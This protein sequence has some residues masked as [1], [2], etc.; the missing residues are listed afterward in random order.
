MLTRLMRLRHACK[1]ARNLLGTEKI[2][3]YYDDGFTFSVGVDP[4]E[5]DVDIGNVKACVEDRGGVVK[6]DLCGQTYR[7]TGRAPRR[8]HAKREAYRAALYFVEVMLPAYR[9]KAP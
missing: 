8:S 7:F 3:P 6:A 9:K 5:F 2:W 1:K 4:D